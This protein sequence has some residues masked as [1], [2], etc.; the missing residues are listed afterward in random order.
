MRSI[1]ISD[2]FL[3]FSNCVGSLCPSSLFLPNLKYSPQ[4]LLKAKGFFFDKSVG[5]KGRNVCAGRFPF[6]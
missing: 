3:F 4:K 1:T 6:V 5:D 2:T